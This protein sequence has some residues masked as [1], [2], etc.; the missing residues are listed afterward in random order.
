M[1]NS[2]VDSSGGSSSTA[3]VQPSDIM[4]PELKPGENPGYLANVKAA[5]APNHKAEI[6][7]LKTVADV[8]TPPDGTIRLAPKGFDLSQD[9]ILQIEPY[10]PGFLAEATH[11]A[12][13][14]IGSTIGVGLASPTGPGAIGGGAAGG[15]VGSAANSGIA[16]YMYPEETWGDAAKDAVIQGVVGGAT[17]GIGH[18]LGLA[19]KALLPQSWVEAGGMAAEKLIPGAGKFVPGGAEDVLPLMGKSVN[20]LNKGA[21]LGKVGSGEGALVEAIPVLRNKVAETL[22][23]AN[24]KLAPNEAMASADQEVTRM[25]QRMTGGG[26]NPT[27]QTLGSLAGYKPGLPD[28]ALAN[29]LLRQFQREG[30]D[31]SRFMKEPPVANWLAQGVKTEAVPMTTA[32]LMKGRL[33]GNNK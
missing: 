23:N 25:L 17:G 12:F 20:P 15:A 1:A 27:P 10:K 11:S 33:L 21:V 13:P 32:E 14:I 29:N 9:E 4:K 8:Y 16:K 3:S 31:I 19:S 26:S 30:I 5:F 6:D 18:G 7:Y 24:P 2:I 22:V 28:G